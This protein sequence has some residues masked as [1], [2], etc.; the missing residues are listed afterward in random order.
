[1]WAFIILSII[2]FPFAVYILYLGAGALEDAKM[3]RL[4]AEAWRDHE[5]AELAKTQTSREG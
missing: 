1:M 4:R 5:A 2:A 3:E